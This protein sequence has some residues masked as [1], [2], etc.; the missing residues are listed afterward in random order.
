[1]VITVPSPRKLQVVFFY[2][3]PWSTPVKLGMQCLLQPYFCVLFLKDDSPPDYSHFTLGSFHWFQLNTV[4]LF[5][6]DKAV[7][8]K[9]YFGI[10][11]MAPS[12][13][14]NGAFQWLWFLRIETVESTVW[15]QR[16]CHPFVCVRACVWERGSLLL[17]Y[18]FPACLGSSWS[19]CSLVR[20]QC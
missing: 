1:M 20:Q 2:F 8:T 6:N 17:L 16:L 14:I 7:T 4:K 18:L 11:L 12:W 13:F 3:C 10:V 15:Q 9:N 19:H 5:W